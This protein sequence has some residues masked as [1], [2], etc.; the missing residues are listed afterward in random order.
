MILLFRERAIIKNETRF[1]TYMRT[2]G[3]KFNF[4]AQIVV[5]IKIKIIQ[6]SVLTR[7][8]LTIFL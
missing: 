5:F 2:Y 8:K 1:L 6:K 3:P 4:I 7:N